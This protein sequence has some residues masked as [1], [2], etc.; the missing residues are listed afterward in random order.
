MIQTRIKQRF[1]TLA[2]WLSNDIV[3][4]EGELAVV[5]CGQQ[6]RFKVGDGSKRFSQ[7]QFIDQDQL[8]TKWM[9]AEA[10]SQGIHAQ[11]VPYGFAAGAYLCANANFSQALGYSSQTLSADMYSFV[12]NGDDTRAIG[13]YYSS[14]G[15]GSFNINPKDGLSGFWIGTASMA[16]LLAQKQDN[17]VFGSTQ[18]WGSDLNFV[19]AEGQI[20]IWTDKDTV[21]SS[22][23]GTEISIDIP[24]IKIGDGSAYN[25]D[26]PFVGD[27]IAIK[28]LSALYQHVAD[29]SCHLSSGERDSWNHKITVGSLADPTD[30]GVVG[31]TLVMT[32][33]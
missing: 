23:Q 31:E 20:V 11:S 5:D 21:V 24:G 33:N 1:D 18:E 22:V 25:V 9:T 12:W 28:T 14:N 10:V 4:L 7:L 32:R 8:C 30:D 29:Q 13:D 15:K 16:S 2:N 17:I 3:L 19:P 26:L 27:D 6:T